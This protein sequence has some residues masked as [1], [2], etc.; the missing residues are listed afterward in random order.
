M[1]MPETIRTREPFDSSRIFSTASVSRDFAVSVFGCC[2]SAVPRASV[3]RRLAVKFRASEVMEA[4]HNCCF[5][6]PSFVPSRSCERRS[7]GREVSAIEVFGV[8]KSG[9][10]YNW[11]VKVASVEEGKGGSAKEAQGGNLEPRDGRSHLRR[12]RGALEEGVGPERGPGRDPQARVENVVHRANKRQR[13]V[14]GRRGALRQHIWML[15]AVAQAEHA[16]KDDSSPEGA[17][18]G[19]KVAR[20]VEVKAHDA[21]VGLKL[22]DEDTPDLGVRGRGL[23]F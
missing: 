13:E 15:V 2:C 18:Q 21:L 1:S 20:D 17:G 4:C 11:P 8:S 7:R 6:A 12:Q 14:R 9:V 5:E 16:R 10:A 3:L 22:P 23:G 19:Y